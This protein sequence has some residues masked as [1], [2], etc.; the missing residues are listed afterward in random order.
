MIKFSSYLLALIVLASFIANAQS[1]TA[2]KAVATITATANVVGGNVDLVVMKDMEIEIASLSPTELT[3]DPQRNPQ[4]GEIKIV[5]NPNSMVRVTYERES[6]LRHEGG[7]S[8]L[9]FTY[10]LSGGTSVV[11]SQSIL[12]TQNNQIRLSNEGTYY[13]W[14]GGRLS[15]IENIVPGN[16][17]MELTVELEYIL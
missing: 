14:V 8:Q 2:T 9:F 1:P 3:L 7:S 12:L 16:Y 17:D 5:G 13:V 6:I 4:S 10:N 15:G 11:Q